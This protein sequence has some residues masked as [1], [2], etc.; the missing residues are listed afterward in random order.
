MCSLRLP[1]VEV[2]K[3]QR[4]IRSWAWVGD[5]SGYHVE[6]LCSTRGLGVSEAGRMQEALL[7]CVKLVCEV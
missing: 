2:L 4:H 7:S 1:T 3:A 5:L 6:R